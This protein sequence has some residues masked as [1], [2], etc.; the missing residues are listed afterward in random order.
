MEGCARRKRPGRWRL[1][2]P[3]AKDGTAGGGQWTWTVGS[4]QWAAWVD[5]PGLGVVVVALS[6]KEKKK[7]KKKKKKGAMSPFGSWEVGAR[8]QHTPSAQRPAPGSLSFSLGAGQGTRVGLGWIDPW[9]CW[10]TPPGQGMCLTTRKGE[11]S[12]STT[13]LPP[14]LNRHGPMSL[15]PSCLIG[16]CPVGF[17]F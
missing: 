8:G 4:G 15:D 17:S 16:S 7:K 3:G 14:S 10:E 2:R 9:H 13:L 12:T 11:I 1:L 6:K 5:Q